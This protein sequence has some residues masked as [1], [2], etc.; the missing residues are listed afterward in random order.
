MLDKKLF[1]GITSR[2]P[3]CKMKVLDLRELDVS[4]YFRLFQS[5]QKRVTTVRQSE[6]KE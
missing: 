1:A 2:K 6:F 5:Q 4:K 3:C